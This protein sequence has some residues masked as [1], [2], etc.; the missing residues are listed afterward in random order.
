M[1]PMPETQRRA[2]KKEETKGKGLEGSKGK[3]KS[4]HKVRIGA[5]F[6]GGRTIIQS[7]R[8][9]V[10]TTETI[11]RYRSTI[12]GYRCCFNCRRFET[13]SANSGT[14]EVAGETF[15]EYKGKGSCLVSSI[16]RWHNFSGQA[17]KRLMETMCMLKILEMLHIRSFYIDC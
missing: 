9:I 17:D 10:W 5:C 2:S 12:C 8:T 14:I 13:F 1:V 4:R 16:S 7:I 11:C 6:H 3:R 15:L